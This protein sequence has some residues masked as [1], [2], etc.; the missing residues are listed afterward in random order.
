MDNSH[1][2]APISLALLWTPS[3]GRSSWRRR[4]PCSTSSSSTANCRQQQR[5]EQWC[6]CG[7]TQQASSE[8]CSS[9]RSSSCSCGRNFWLGECAG[10][11]RAACPSRGT[12]RCF[13]TSCSRATGHQQRLAGSRHLGPWWYCCQSS[14]RQLQAQ[15]LRLRLLPLLLLLLPVPAPA[16]VAAPAA[17]YGQPDAGAAA[18]GA[19]K[20]SPLYA[21]AAPAAHVRGGG[22]CSSPLGT[23]H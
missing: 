19:A 18:V 10:C 14:G 13:S 15:L 16:A 7:P 9:W 6:G 22:V 4:R 1:M 2:V 11:S 8:Q 21:P 3:S 5:L 17:L 12:T 20:P 23:S